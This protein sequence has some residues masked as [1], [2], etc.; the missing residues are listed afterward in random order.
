MVTSTNTTSARPGPGFLIVIEGIDGTGKSTL[1]AELAETLRQ[2]GRS[3]LLT[4]EP[5]HGPYGRRLRELAIAGREEVTPEEETELFIADRREHV[6]Q[7]IGPA[8]AAGQT[9]V[10]DRYYYSTMAYQGARGVDPAQIEAR[11]RDF[12]PQ[13]DLL[14][15]LDLPV[16]EAL[17]RI[18]RKRGSIPDQFEGAEYLARVRRIFET[19]HHP[20]LL[21]L[22]ARTSTRQ[23]MDQI[24]SRLTD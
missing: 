21:K 2:R 1:A 7:E 3:V 5:T 20:E 24:L 16:E 23:M 11:H 12:A 18:I 6:A 4:Y 9:V 15:L 17:D 8:L 19:I 10:M 22:D 13:P 14:V